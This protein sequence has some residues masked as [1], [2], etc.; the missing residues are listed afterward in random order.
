M[1]LKVRSFEPLIGGST[2]SVKLLASEAVRLDC[3]LPPFRAR[4]LVPRALVAAPICKVPAVRV[5]V[6]V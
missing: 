5:V 3:K 2:A 6:A 4:A 1:P